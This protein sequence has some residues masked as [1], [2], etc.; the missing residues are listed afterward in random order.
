MMLL[1][2]CP[3]HIQQCACVQT[4]MCFSAI[5]SRLLTILHEGEI[6]QRTQ[7][8]VEVM[9]A[10]RKDGFK[11]SICSPSNVDGRS[12]VCDQEGRLQSEYL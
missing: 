3:C 8:M 11:V 4:R 7:Y 9:F 6:E 12:D 10:I 1:H 5:F 2:S